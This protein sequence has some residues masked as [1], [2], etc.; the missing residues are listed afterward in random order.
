MTVITTTLRVAA[1]GSVSV[2][3]K[4]PEGEYQ[5]TITVAAP[6]RSGKPFTMKDFPVHDEPWDDGLSLRRE[7]LYDDEGRLR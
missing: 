5:A 3:D 6:S 1:D 2:A 7:H 4:L